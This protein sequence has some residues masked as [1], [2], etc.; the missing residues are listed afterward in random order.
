MSTP[1]LAASALEEQLRRMLPPA[2]GS[3]GAAGL[4]VDLTHLRVVRD[5]CGDDGG[6]NHLARQ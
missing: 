4:V 5:S 2:R 6:P 3:D 1:R